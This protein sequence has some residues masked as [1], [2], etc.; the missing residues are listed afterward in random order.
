MALFRYDNDLW[1]DPFSD[2]DQMFQRMLGTRV[3]NPLFYSDS[4]VTS[5][6]RV[7]LFADDNG[8]KVIAELPGIPKDKIDISLENAVLNISAELKE[9]SEAA[10]TQ[11]LTR[12]IS[13]NEDVDAEKVAAT[14]QDG[15]LAVTLPKK[16]E[17]KPHT[18]K[19]KG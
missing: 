11:K 18:I 5:G 8:Y 17:R 1:R 7:D 15:L 4:S 12:S 19:I 13:V 14:Y 10:K 2:L 3:P 6:F 9:E 16:A